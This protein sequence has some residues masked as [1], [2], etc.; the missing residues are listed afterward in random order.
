MTSP[1]YYAVGQTFGASQS[2]DDPGSCLCAGTSITTPSGEI[3]V[4]DLS[5]GNFVL[6]VSGAR[7][8]VVS[9]RR[10]SYPHRLLAAQPALRPIRIGAGSLDGCLPRRDLF[11]SRD[12][13]LLVDG[14]LVPAM[15]LTNGVTITVEQH[16]FRVDYIQIDIAAHGL[17]FAEGAAAETVVAE[18]G[19]AAAAGPYTSI[20]GWGHPVYAPKVEHGY[21]LEAIRCRLAGLA[22]LMVTP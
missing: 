13:S 21:A 7:R 18:D 20:P 5:V 14:V 6:T 12:Q 22:G 19:P 8:P 15:L 4:E 17:L 2:P 10:W 1:D 11:V 16:V 3:P 9:V